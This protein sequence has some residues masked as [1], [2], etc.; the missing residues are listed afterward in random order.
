MTV[1]EDDRNNKPPVAAEMTTADAL[2]SS[3]LR[4]FYDSIVEQGTP[5][6]FLDLL[7][8]LDAAER[9]AKGKAV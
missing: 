5:D 4:N 9:A 1:K 8:K 6:H 2:I 3:K 7:E